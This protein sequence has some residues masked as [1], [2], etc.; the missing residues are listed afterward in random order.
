MVTSPKSYININNERILKEN[1]NI[2]SR[3]ISMGTLHRAF[4]V[5]G[6]IALATASQI[7]RHDSQ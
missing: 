2:T 3:Y 7:P 5:S 4:A 6:S 1:I